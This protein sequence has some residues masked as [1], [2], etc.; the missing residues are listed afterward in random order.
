MPD[1]RKP[2]SVCN[3][4]TKTHTKKKCFLALQYSGGGGSVVF[5]IQI[6]VH[7]RVKR[8]TENVLWFLLRGY[9]VKVVVK[10]ALHGLAQEQ[11]CDV[12]HAYIVKAVLKLL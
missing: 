2:S 6:R 9:S 5:G 11:S 3:G 12:L 8:S 4:E 7:P 1:T 10:P